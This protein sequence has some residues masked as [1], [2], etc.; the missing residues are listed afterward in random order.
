M[1][2]KRDDEIVGVKVLGKALTLLCHVDDYICQ[3]IGITIE[4]LL[5]QAGLDE[6]I[7][8]RKIMNYTQW[9]CRQ[10][11]ICRNESIR[12]VIKAAARIRSVQQRIICRE[13][14]IRK[15]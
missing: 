11:I 9:T 8:G 3:R 13:I 10:K 7:E 2:G 6:G 12:T 14:R 1:N 15:V 4:I 5:L